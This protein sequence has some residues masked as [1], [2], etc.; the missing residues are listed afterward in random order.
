MALAASLPKSVPARAGPAPVPQGFPPAMTISAEQ[1]KAM[2][3][4]NR[5]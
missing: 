2:Q 3:Q 4:P 1:M 5:R